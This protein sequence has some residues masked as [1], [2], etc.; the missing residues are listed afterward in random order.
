MPR[1]AQ[2]KTPEQEAQQ[3]LKKFKIKS[4]P[5][6]VKDIAK[7]LGLNVISYD[8]GTDVSGILVIERGKGTIGYNPDNHRVRQRFTIAHELGHYQLHTTDELTDG[9]FIDKDFIVKFRSEKKYSAQE[10]T[11]EKEANEFAAE[12][13]MPKEL[14]LAEIKKKAYANLSEI[15]CIEKLANTFDVSVPA[16]TIRANRVDLF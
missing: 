12:L 6:P 11:Q 10:A 14:L 9:I 7:N 16:M 5:V 2:L 3:I 1:N 15:K 4:A 8:L 13:L